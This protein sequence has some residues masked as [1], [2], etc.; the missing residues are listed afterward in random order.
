MT[1]LVIPHTDAPRPLILL[2]D[3]TGAPHGWVS[4]QCALTCQAGG[5]VDRALGAQ[6][7]TF[8]GGTSRLTG[9]RSEL[10]I[11]S[12]LALRGRNPRGWIPQPPALCNTLLFQRDHG[13]CCYCGAHKPAHAL[14]RDHVTPLSRGGADHWNN[15][16][17]ACKPCNQRKG[18]A[19]PQDVGMLMLYVPYTP[20]LCEGLILRNRRILADQM[21]FLQSLLPENSRCRAGN[22][23][24]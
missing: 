21:E 8:H 23:N 19:R 13:L 24:G 18:A 15:V 1:P 2:V 9:Q 11:S 22:H 17:T 10:V 14:T 6:T 3:V 16:V 20:S 12:I 5:R 4:W 7:F